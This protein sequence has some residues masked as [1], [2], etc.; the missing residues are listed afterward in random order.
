MLIHKLIVISPNSLTQLL[1][2]DSAQLP[3]QQL[4]VSQA[5]SC[6]TF[7]R[8]WTNPDVTRGRKQ[9]AVVSQSGSCKHVGSLSSSPPKEILGPPRWYEA[10]YACSCMALKLWRDA[11]AEE[12]APWLAAK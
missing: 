5:R 4:T 8:H 6:L 7:D 2:Q 11:T 9:L 12:A 3:V 10:Y 1:C